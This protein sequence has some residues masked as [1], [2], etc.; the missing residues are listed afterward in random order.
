MQAEEWILSKCGES[1][2]PVEV[3]FT[4]ADLPPGVTPELVKY[5]FWKLKRTK[6]ISG[7]ILITDNAGCSMQ[8]KC[9]E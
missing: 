6:R 1:G 4:K 7:Y 2:Q 5:A 3:S 9:G 8:L